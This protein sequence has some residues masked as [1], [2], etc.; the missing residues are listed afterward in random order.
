[1]A[2]LR[3]VCLRPCVRVGGRWG[4]VNFH[5]AAFDIPAIF[6]WCPLFEDTHVLGFPRTF[7][8]QN[9]LIY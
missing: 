9:A 6:P 5:M 1:M 4:V 3:G 7:L 8:H 2:W